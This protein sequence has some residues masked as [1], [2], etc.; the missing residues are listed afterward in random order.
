MSK[1]WLIPLVPGGPGKA[2]LDADLPLA[3]PEE[4]ERILDLAGGTDGNRRAAQGC[5]GMC[6][7]PTSAAEWRVGGNKS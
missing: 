1:T 4:L 6:S 2:S 3:S 5:D 7:C